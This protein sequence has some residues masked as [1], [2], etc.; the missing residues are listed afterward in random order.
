M[1]NDIQSAYSRFQGVLDQH[2]NTSFKRQTFTMNYKNCHPWM[3]DALQFQI[4][5][6][7]KLHSF[8]SR[9][10]IS[11]EA[12]KVAKKAL[13]SSLRNAEITYFG[14]QLEMNKKDIG[15]NGK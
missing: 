13:Q 3:T 1:S 14:N 8:A 5:P 4:K 6:K 12:Y 9:D 2:L 11:M 7:N 10:D 15:K